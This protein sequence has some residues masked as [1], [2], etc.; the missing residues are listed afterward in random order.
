MVA[1]CLC[2]LNIQCFEI[3]INLSYILKSLHYKLEPNVIKSIRENYMHNMYWA[4][5]VGIAQLVLETGV[6]SQLFWCLCVGK[7]SIVLE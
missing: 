2:I 3:K 6:R 4:L 5:K 1:T 7:Y